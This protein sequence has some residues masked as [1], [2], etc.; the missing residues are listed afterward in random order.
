MVRKNFIP[1]KAIQK[2]KYVDT[3]LG[4]LTIVNSKRNG[5]R[6]EFRKELVEKLGVTDTITVCYDEERVIFFKPSEA[7]DTVVFNVRESS[8]KAVIY[9]YQLVE[10]LTQF[11]GL[12]FDDRV[13]HTIGEGGF[14]AFEEDGQPVLFVKRTSTNETLCETNTDKAIESEV[15]A[16]E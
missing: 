10:E 12:N 6:I 15:E 7:S 13:C 1:S 16:N 14:D 4:L 3:S 5:R 9:S 11:F 2:A 8:G